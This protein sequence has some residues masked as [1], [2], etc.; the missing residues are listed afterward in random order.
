MF[1]A[2]ILSAAD[3]QLIL[4]AV[5]MPALRATLSNVEDIADTSGPS[6]P[7]DSEIPRRVPRRGTLPV[8]GLRSSTNQ[9]EHGH[10]R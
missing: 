6:R 7:F 1:T 8:T 9:M 3:G 10:E 5:E 4:G 2:F